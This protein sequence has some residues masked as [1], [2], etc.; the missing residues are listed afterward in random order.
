VFADYVSYIETRMVL[1]FANQRAAGSSSL[2]CRGVA[3]TIGLDFVL[4][5]VIIVLFI[6]LLAYVFRF[7]GSPAW[8]GVL[9]EFLP[10]VYSSVP[11]VNYFNDFFEKIIITA[12]GKLKIVSVNAFDAYWQYFR[13]FWM[14]SGSRFVHIR[15]GEYEMR[16]KDGAFMGI[17]VYSTLL[18]SVWVWLYLLSSMGVRTLVFFA[19]WLARLERHFFLSR[20]LVRHPLKVLG[21]FLMLLYAVP[22]LLIRALG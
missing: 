3:I 20:F 13:D 14:Q 4:T 17:F 22:L 9:N 12:D 15:G 2:T 19:S 18:T 21:Y 1:S 11:R 16:S 10:G 7:L 5:L 6:S 8:I